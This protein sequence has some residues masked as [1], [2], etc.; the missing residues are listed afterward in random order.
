MAL[1][2]SEPELVRLAGA[3]DPNA[4]SA[5]V[6]GHRRRLQ[7][8]AK[9][10]L[11]SRE[12]R[13]DLV[14]DVVHRLLHDGKRALREWQPF[15]PFAAY[16]STIAWR[17]G[18][19]AVGVQSRLPG[20]GHLALPPG[21]DPPGDR[22]IPAASAQVGDPHALAVSADQAQVVREA[23][24]DLPP[25]DQILLKL[26]FYE[27]MQPAEIGRILGLSSGTAR[28]AVFDALRR[29]RKRLEPH[30]DLLYPH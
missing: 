7:L 19:Q 1:P 2:Q 20:G 3:C 30:A 29:L 11:K 21:G 13:E 24:A 22:W 10:F 27:E 9:R 18:L 8:V 5:L 4:F 12:E 17:R 26:R 14:Q 6:D 25:R 16:V 28:K 23:L 15:A